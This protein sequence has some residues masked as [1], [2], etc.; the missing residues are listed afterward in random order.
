MV[1]KSIFVEH[2][3]TRTMFKDW[4][5]KVGFQNRGVQWD[6]PMARWAG[7]GK[8]WTELMT[9]LLGTCQRTCATKKRRDLTPLSLGIGTWRG[10]DMEIKAETDFGHPDLT[11]FGQTDFGQLWPNQLRKVG[12]RKGGG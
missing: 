2:G 6:T 5:H 1:E 12:A 9:P 8:D 11:D 7:E 10:T 3:G 4:K